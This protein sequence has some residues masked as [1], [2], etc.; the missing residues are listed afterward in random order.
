MLLVWGAACLAL[1]L[2]GLKR[3]GIPVVGSLLTWLIIPQVAGYSLI[4]NGS[5]DSPVHPASLLVFVTMVVWLLGG[6]LAVLA[7]GR[8]TLPLWMLALVVVLGG[9]WLST[10]SATGSAALR[11][12]LDLVVAPAG[13]FVLYRVADSRSPHL[14]RQL[15]HAFLGAS[16]F[17]AILAFAQVLSHNVIFFSDY[18]KKLYWYTENV[19]RAVGTADSP[20]TLALLLGIATV[21]AS[22][23]RS[24][25]WRVSLALLF[26]AATLTTGSRFGVAV[27]VF[28][29][30]YSIIFRGRRF[31]AGQV[32]A[33]AV[34]VGV[35]ILI[36]QSELSE[37]VLSRIADDRG[38]TRLRESAVDYFFGDMSSIIVTGHGAGQGV[39]LRTQGILESSLENGL[40]IYAYEYGIL[41]TLLLVLLQLV[42]VISHARK[43]RTFGGLVLWLVG[44]LGVMASSS[45]GASGT[46]AVIWW[47][48]VAIACTFQ[49]HTTDHDLDVSD[50]QKSTVGH[51]T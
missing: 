4:G 32:V 30:L 38:S 35:G 8:A 24:T 49:P 15:L 36:F 37:G 40:L 14:R 29:L 20:V 10:Y 39:A 51:L 27:A 12:F 6:R 43:T 25:P 1:A 45:I 50:H 31:T 13:W 42:M 19:T 2:W 47:C 48:S 7:N 21:A 11:I 28:G 5:A 9:M 41:L 46:A 16:A 33:A 44:L 17:N 23:L 26:C 22:W 18:Y 3:P 34:T